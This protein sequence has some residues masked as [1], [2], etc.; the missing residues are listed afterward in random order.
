VSGPRETEVRRLHRE[1]PK[2]WFLRVSAALFGLLVLVSLVDVLAGSDVLLEGRQV[3]NLSRFLSE[4]R[5]RDRDGRFLQGTEVLAWAGEILD[6][7][8]FAAAGATLAISIVAIV[9]AALASVPLSLLAARSFAHPEAFGPGPRPPS[10]PARLAWWTVTSTTRTIFVFLRALPEYVIA[11]LLLTMLGPTAWTAVLALMI[12]NVG[13]LG[14]LY[15]ETV[16]NLP[17]RVP[18]TLR[19]IGA[20]RLQIAVLGIAPAVIP[21]LLVYFFYRWETCVREA[22]VLGML[23]IFSLG[24]FIVDARAHNHYDEML[25]LVLIGAAIVIVGDVVSAIARGVIRRAG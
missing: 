13:I 1:R 25:F 4:L 14:R 17:A 18:S 12:H 8:G 11:F 6:R 24:Y 21:R 16:E 3:D 19:G 20:G 15:A 22:T 5:P 7:R 9:L 23:G 10:L 2:S